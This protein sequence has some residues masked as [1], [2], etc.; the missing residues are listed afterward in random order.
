MNRL[1]TGAAIAACLTLSAGTATAEIGW[2]IGVG[3]GRSDNAN[4][5]ETGKI[6][7][8]LMTLGGALAYEFEGPRVQA[9]LSGYGTYLDYLDNTYDSDFLA[10]GDGSLVFGIVPER[11]LWTFEDTFGQITINQFEPV[12]PE[13]RQNANYFS[14]GPDV[15]LRLGSQTDLRIG[16]RYADSRYES[17]NTANDSR[18]SGDIAVIRRSS[19]NVAWSA[20]ASASRV[21]YDLPGNPGYDLQSVFGRLEAQ[22]ARQT[23]NLDL[24]A[25]RISDSGQSFTNPLV[26][27]TWNRNLTPSWT[28]DLSLGSEYQ[29]TG[30]RF[31]AGAG[32]PDGG[33]GGVNVS[34][35]PSENYRG[36]LTF[37]FTRPRTGFYIGTGYSKDN[38]VRSGQED[39]TAWN[40]RIG[41]SR[42][43]TQRLQGFADAAYEK[44]DFQS[45]VGNDKTKRLSTRLDWSLGR[46]TFVTLGY[47]YEGRSSDI[48]TNGYTENLIYLS[49]SYRYGTIGEP[50]NFAF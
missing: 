5:V 41:I 44:R 15:I 19:P 48:G 37:T 23:V 47:R 4:R 20:V 21:E 9:S 31:V 14:T 3:A 7:D 13:N 22:G 35:I 10:S 12:T 43:F 2:S 45:S 49:L 18:L 24:G 28:M 42:R 36:G 50:R 46:A 16:G 32:G 17:T 26:R 27:L 34:N 25:T 29:N 1:I 33:T 39:Q 40:T 38:Y 11:F 6:D 8:T 30:D